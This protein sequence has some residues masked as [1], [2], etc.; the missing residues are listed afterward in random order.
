MLTGVMPWAI[1]NEE[2]GW[3]QT[4]VASNDFLR[5]TLPISHEAD[6]L[7]QRMLTEHEED[8]ISLAEVQ[9]LAARV[10]H[11]WMSDEEIAR[12]EPHL[13][14]VARMCRPEPPKPRQKPTYVPIPSMGDGWSSSSSW[15]ELLLG[16]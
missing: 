1:A 16:L 13:Q 2:D 15:G 14:R 6:A 4:F 10:E 8:C 7:L 9:K 11:F 3:Y 12:A 5:Y